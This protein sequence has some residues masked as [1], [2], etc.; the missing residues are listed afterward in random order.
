MAFKK[1]FPILILIIVCFQLQAFRLYPMSRDFSPSGSGMIQ[2]FSLENDTDDVAAIKI[3][4]A[5]RVVDQFGEE[6]LSLV[7]D[8][9]GIYP[10]QVIL[11]PRSTQKIR[12][13]WLGEKTVGKELHYRIVAE[14]LPV[15]L[16][17]E[18][19]GTS[20]TF[21]MKFV[22]TLYV[23]PQ[24]DPRPSVEVK[25]IRPSADKRQLIVEIVNNGSLKMMMDHFELE[26]ESSGK[27]AKL[28]GEDLDGLYKENLL[29]GDSRII[30]VKTPPGLDIIN[31]NGKVLF[32][33]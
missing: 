4:I 31:V 16:K 3:H 20:L 32:K 18:T 17:K 27:K 9:F 1:L 19:G 12:I 30:K 33:E 14:Q 7:S 26:L 5:E 6:D 21:L 25:S 15:N 11:K 2:N 22:G 28:P 29:S 13:Q 10:S 23:I 8:D 24:N